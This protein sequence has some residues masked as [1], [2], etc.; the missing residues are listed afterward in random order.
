MG[1]IGTSSI[2]RALAG[3]GLLLALMLAASLEAGAPGPPFR[4]PRDVAFTGDGAALLV[5]DHTAGELVQ[6]TV[7]DG[8]VVRRTP[9]PSPMAVRTSG[10]RVYVSLFHADAVA[11][12]EAA[13]LRVLRRFRVGAY[14][15]PLAVAPRAHLLFAGNT[16]TRDVSVVPLSSG[17]ERTRVRCSGRPSALAVSPDEK[18]LA[19]AH[20]TPTGDATREDNAATVAVFEVPSLKKRT[21]IRLP[22]GSVIIRGLAFSP[23]GRWLCAAH[24]LGRYNL[25]TTQLDRGWVNTN[26]LSIVDMRGLKH[27]ATVLLDQAQE[28]A[29]DPWDVEFS[30]D[31]KVLWVTLSGVHEVARIDFDRMMRWIGGGLPDDHPLNRTSPEWALTTRNIW[32]E[33]KLNPARRSD[34]VNDLSALYVGDLI[35]RFRLPGNGPRGMALS[36]DGRTV[37]AAQY[38]SGGVSFLDPQGRVRR[39]ASLGA[40]PRETPERRG[41]RTFHDGT[42]AF[43]H[44][45][46]C[47]TCHPEGRADGLN[48]DLLN[49][50]IGNP[51]NTRSLLL[52][53]RRGV[54]MSHG[55]RGNVRIAAT[56]GFRFILFR[57][58]QPREVEDVL[59][60]LRSMEPMPSPYLTGPGRTRLSPRALLGKAIFDSPRTKCR[61]CHSGPLYTDGKLYDTGTRGPYDTDGRFVTPTLVEVWRT[62]PYLHDGRARTMDEVLTR[63]NQKDKHGVTSHLTREQREALSE[64]VLSL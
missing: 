45:L 53:H 47:A 50:G 57:T 28:G 3:L 58:P 33:I 34:L 6:I 36:P 21:E 27:Y 18:H 8:K 29:A 48:W 26:A 60:Y 51:K 20:L 19:V 56:A 64:Y 44:W 17:R 31:G 14:P 13:S 30:G 9:L 39:T 61:T 32:Q 43:Q 49:D 22:A 2:I 16:G 5:T 41:E 12:L 7:S 40:S 46:S 4:S 42:L 10:A 55:V 35:E 25:P 24:A 38:F 62:P 1:R 59:A 37:A 11:E 54:M 63:F 15:E 23:D 52:A